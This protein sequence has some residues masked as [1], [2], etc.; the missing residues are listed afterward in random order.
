MQNFKHA[1]SARSFWGKAMLWYT[2]V[3]PG[4]VLNLRK[5]KLAARRS[6]MKMGVFAMGVCEPRGAILHAI[7]LPDGQLDSRRETTGI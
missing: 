6:L 3:H 2:E 7:T 4:W 5:G 1:W